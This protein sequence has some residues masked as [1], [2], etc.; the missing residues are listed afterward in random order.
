MYDLISDN[1]ACSF[2]F[3]IDD[4][5]FEEGQTDYQEMNTVIDGGLEAVPDNL[6][7][8]DTLN[9]KH[10]VLTKFSDNE[11]DEVRSSDTVEEGKGLSL[12][13]RFGLRYGFYYVSQDTYLAI[14]ASHAKRYG[15]R[16]EKERLNRLALQWVLRA[17]GRNEQFVRAALDEIVG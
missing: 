15:L 9:R 6:L 17:G 3:F 12:V 4:L 13:E 11:S 14:V 10:L 1:P 5:S 2:I 16:M 8:Y 7:F